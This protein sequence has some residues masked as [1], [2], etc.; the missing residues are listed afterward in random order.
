MTQHGGISQ[1]PPKKGL[2]KA[3]IENILKYNFKNYNLLF[4]VKKY[5]Y[6]A[7]P[8]VTPYCIVLILIK[9]LGTLPP[10]PEL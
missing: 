10:Q 7:D 4:Y 8:S 2:E 3:G 6:Q 1:N 9:K 5:T